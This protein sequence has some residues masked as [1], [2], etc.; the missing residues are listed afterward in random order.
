MA[1]KSIRTL[2]HKQQPSQH[3]NHSIYLQAEL[4]QESVL[5]W[6]EGHALLEA[7]EH[8]VVPGSAPPRGEVVEQ[9]GAGDGLE[10]KE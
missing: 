9:T 3:H 8:V 5:I 7:K 2:V 6:A 10:T 4:G 1:S